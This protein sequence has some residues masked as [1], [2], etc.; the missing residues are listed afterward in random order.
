MCKSDSGQKQ[1][2]Q[3]ADDDSPHLTR[4]FLVG[5][6]LLMQ[7][8]LKLNIKDKA[9]SLSDF[10]IKIGNSLE[11]EG[12]NNTKCGDRHSVPHGE[13]KEISCSPPLI[14]RYLVIQSLSSLRLNIIEVEV[15]AAG[16][17]VE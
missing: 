4:F 10:E 15:F 11:N 1:N 16:L 9:N 12:R 8:R 7:R 13:S 3:S 5:K 2:E 14:G 17:Q 6:E